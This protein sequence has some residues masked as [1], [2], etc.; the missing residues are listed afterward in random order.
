MTQTGEELIAGPENT[1]GHFDELISGLLVLSE[2]HIIGKLSARTAREEIDYDTITYRY[3]TPPL[4][5]EL[6]GYSGDISVGVYREDHISPADGSDVEPPAYGEIQINFAGQSGGERKTIERRREVYGRNSLDEKD[7]A[8]LEATLG[9]YVAAARE[10]SA[11]D[12]KAKG[13]SDEAISYLG[14][15]PQ[16]AEI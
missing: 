10:L 15:N 11:E 13:F 3:V 2:R 16:I 5:V 14:L 4:R 8:R 1:E 12:A 6:D 9:L 7:A